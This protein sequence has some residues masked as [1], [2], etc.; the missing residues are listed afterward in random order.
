MHG[1]TRQRL[2][3]GLRYGLV[4]VAA[5]TLLTGAACEGEEEVT[6][7]AT[8]VVTSTATSTPDDTA[9]ATVEPTETAD[10]SDAGTALGRQAGGATCDALF[11]DGLEVGDDTEDVFVCLN[12]PYPGDTVGST[13]EVSGFQAGAFEQNVVIEVWDADGDVLA[14][15]SATA[16]APSMGLFAGE[17]FATVE[18]DA[19]PPSEDISVVAYNASARDGSL[20]FGGQVNVTFEE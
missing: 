17:W 1:M 15:T 3:R 10:P 19:A 18:L 4:V 2:H 16:N 14:R 12:A 5:L 6:P 11:P 20:D 9:T 8:T 13:I 7:T